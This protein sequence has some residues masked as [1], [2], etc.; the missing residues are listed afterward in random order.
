MWWEIF[1]KFLYYCYLR[2]KYQR[3]MEAPPANGMMT[4]HRRLTKIFWRQQSWT[5]CCDLK[6]K[7]VRLGLL[8]G[9]QKTLRLFFFTK[10]TVFCDVTSCSLVH[11]Y[12]CC[13]ISCCNQ[14]LLSWS[15]RQHCPQNFKNLKYFTYV[16]SPISLFS[17]NRLAHYTGWV[18]R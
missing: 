2:A 9:E 1:T 3:R 16:V 4:S 15:C 13:K 18:F 5:R 17:N 14:D 6:W 10:V 7:I 11:K 12:W 8:H